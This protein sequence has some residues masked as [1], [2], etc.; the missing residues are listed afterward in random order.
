VDLL[1]VHL[2]VIPEYEFS[3]EYLLGSTPIEV[4]SV[5]LD[6]LIIIIDFAS[7]YPLLIY[8]NTLLGFPHGLDLVSKGHKIH[9]VTN[10]SEV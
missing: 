4:H 3:D 6:S 2:D 9:K 10:D 8:F 1:T 7:I 5:W